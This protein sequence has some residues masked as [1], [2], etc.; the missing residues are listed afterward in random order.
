MQIESRTIGEFVE[1]FERLFGSYLQPCEESASDTKY[2][3]IRPGRKKYSDWDLK[4]FLL[5]EVKLDQ[6]QQML[7]FVESYPAF[8]AIGHFMT[9][10]DAFVDRGSHTS[11]GKLIQ[12]MAI[13]KNESYAPFLDLSIRK[14]KNSYVKGLFQ[15]PFN[16]EFIS[17][18]MLTAWRKI[19]NGNFIGVNSFIWITV[20][21]LLP[22]Y[23][24]EDDRRAL[25]RKPQKFF[26]SKLGSATYKKAV[27]FLQ[28]S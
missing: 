11:T 16:E 19:K 6:V 28:D 13:M 7:R 10:A 26:A 9:D 17:W 27:A 22:Y 25:L 18:A 1:T 21:Y 20:I 5:D 24:D 8:D 2:F 23:C 15:K 12:I 14:V 4:C 3:K